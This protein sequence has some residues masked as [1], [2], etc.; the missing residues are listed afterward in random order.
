MSKAY[1]VALD[2]FF[3]HHVPSPFDRSREVVRGNERIMFS[4]AAMPG[5]D[6][7]QE[8]PQ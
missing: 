1:D 2:G 4:P 3:I 7:L 8:V 5:N 6:I